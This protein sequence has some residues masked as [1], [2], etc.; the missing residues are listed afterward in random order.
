MSAAT[1]TATALATD[2]IATATTVAPPSSHV[3]TEV[4]VFEAFLL[5]LSRMKEAKMGLQ[6]AMESLSNSYV[7]GFKAKVENELLHPQLSMHLMVNSEIPVDRRKA[8][9][10]DVLKQFR[11]SGAVMLDLLV[12]QGF[13]QVTSIIFHPPMNFDSFDRFACNDLSHLGLKRLPSLRYETVAESSPS[14]SPMED[15][16]VLVRAD[17][18]HTYYLHGKFRLIV[19]VVDASNNAVFNSYDITVHHDAT[20]HHVRECI[21]EC[22]KVQTSSQVTLLNFIVQD[23]SVDS[24]LHAKTMMSAIVWNLSTSILDNSAI[25][26]TAV[27]RFPIKLTPDFMYQAYQLW[28]DNKEP[29]LKHDGC[30]SIAVFEITDGDRDNLSL[31][32]TPMV[33]R[34]LKPAEIMR[35]HRQLQTQFYHQAQRMMK[36][37]NFI[38]IRNVV[39]TSPMMFDPEYMAAEI[40]SEDKHKY[41]HKFERMPYIPAD[42]MHGGAFIRVFQ[43]CESTAPLGMMNYVYGEALISIH[44]S[45]QADGKCYALPRKVAVNPDMNMVELADLLHTFEREMIIHFEVWN[46]AHVTCQRFAVSAQYKLSNVVFTDSVILHAIV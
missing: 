14:P 1:A 41:L 30:V 25:N 20:F 38:N 22:I 46:K 44:V 13:P 32:F 28:L 45:R 5:W 24:E 17:L 4:N 42:P 18:K 39:F 40:L 26:I 37:L 23:Q 29:V 7:F 43:T 36:R 33:P 3:D 19:K 15:M 21:E 8:I 9:F 31:H 2:A 34:S 10:V 6:F 27:V 11:D 16:L 35:Y 12:Q